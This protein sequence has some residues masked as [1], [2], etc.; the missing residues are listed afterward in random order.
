MRKRDQDVGQSAAGLFLWRRKKG[1]ISGTSLYLASYSLWISFFLP[2]GLSWSPFESSFIFL[3]FLAFFLFLF[4]FSSF[5]KYI[6]H[7]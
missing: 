5:H 4:L 2:L 1:K 6:S 7:F 3:S